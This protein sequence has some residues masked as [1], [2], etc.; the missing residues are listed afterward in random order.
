M[1]GR[2]EALLGDLSAHVGQ[3]DEM[4]DLDAPGYFTAQV[5]GRLSFLSIYKITY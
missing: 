2:V 1:Q 4:Y 3:G 5:G